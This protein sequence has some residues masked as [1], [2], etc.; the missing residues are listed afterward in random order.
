MNPNRR[1][2]ILSLALGLPALTRAEGFASE[3][4]PL[5]IG[6]TLLLP[7]KILGETRR[8]NVW[9]PTGFAESPTARIPLL[10][11]PDGGIEEDFLH[12]AGLLQISIANGTM[13]PHLLVGIENTERRR[14]LTPPTEDERDRKIAPRVGGSAAFRSFIREELIPAVQARW[15]VTGERTIMGESLAGL[16][17]VETW[18]REPALFQTCLAFDP[19][20]WWNR[21]SLTALVTPALAQRRNGPQLQISTSSEPSIVAPVDGFVAALQRVGAAR[22]QRDPLPAETHL[23]VYHP[24]ALAAVRRWLGPGKP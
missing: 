14:D 21:E 16:F 22:W 10:V 4:K 17:I 23:T 1:L 24:A 6:Q 19:S 15:R 8:I 13:R 2:L 12:V 20:L 3:V 18:L 11:M 7:S 9:A 5:V